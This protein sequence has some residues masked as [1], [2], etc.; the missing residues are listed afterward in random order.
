MKLKRLRPIAEKLRAEGDAGNLRK[1]LHLVAQ[2]QKNPFRNPDPERFVYR[3][4]PMNIESVRSC[5]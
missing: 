2:F 5:R 1:L 4:V 3:P